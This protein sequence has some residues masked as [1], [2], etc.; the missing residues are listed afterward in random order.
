[1]N[2]NLSVVE[3]LIQKGADINIK[4]DLNGNLLHILARFDG[5]TA[6]QYLVNHGVDINSQD[7]DKTF[8]CFYGLHFITMH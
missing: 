6:I 3:Y 4:S 7:I 2:G 5:F 1:L 8:L